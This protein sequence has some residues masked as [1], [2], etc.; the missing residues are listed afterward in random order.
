MSTIDQ[1][2]AAAAAGEDLPE[3]FIAAAAQPFDTAAGGAAAE[4]DVLVGSSSGAED[5]DSSGSSG[6][7]SSK[8]PLS[9]ERTMAPDVKC[10]PADSSRLG[11]SMLRSNSWW[12]GLGLGSSLNPSRSVGRLVRNI[13]R[14]FGSRSDLAAGKA[15]AAVVI[16]SSHDDDSYTVADNNRRGLA[17]SF[18]YAQLAM[19]R[20]V[21][22]L[23]VPPAYLPGG[24]L[25]AGLSA[26]VG[27]VNS[28]AVRL[29]NAHS[30]NTPKHG[31]SS[32]GGTAAAATGVLVAAEKRETGNVSW[33]VYGAYAQQVGRVTS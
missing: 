3:A 19:T 30:G 12:G 29:S 6:D 18:T 14:M 25:Y 24:A 4:H 10:R 20:S 16:K 15:A 27:R 31:S 22:S 7:T 8:L 5:R 33:K 11:S 2:T 28:A 13:S 21:Q 17:S 32:S 26:S 23:F 9:R 1:A